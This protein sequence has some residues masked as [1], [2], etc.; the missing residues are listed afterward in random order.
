M[1]EM[2]EAL[3]VIAKELCRQLDA[4]PSSGNAW[5]IADEIWRRVLKEQ[6]RIAEICDVM[7]DRE[8]VLAIDA[9]DADLTPIYRRGERVAREI[10]AAI[11]R[12]N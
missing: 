7:G 10:A 6:E 8:D 4:V 2:P 9:G 5:L 1:S 11:R 12:G 3:M